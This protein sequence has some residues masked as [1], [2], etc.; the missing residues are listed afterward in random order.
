MKAWSGRNAEPRI[1]GSPFNEQPG[2]PSRGGART[3]GCGLGLG[4]L[5]LLVVV[6]NAWF[7]WIARHGRLVHDLLTWDWL[8]QPLSGDWAS[9]VFLPTV[10]MVSPALALLVSLCCAT[11][12][13]WGR[14]RASRRTLMIWTICLGVA[15]GGW[16]IACG[17]YV[18]N[19]LDGNL[20]SH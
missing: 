7:F 3:L 2:L 16:P 14:G 11:Y 10:V 6:F 15:I 1:G 12:W 4:V 17:C 18:A 9:A 19:T 13:S 8:R 20:V 5:T